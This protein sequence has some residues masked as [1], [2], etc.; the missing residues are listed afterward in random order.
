MSSPEG[1]KADLSLVTGVHIR[2][3]GHASH[4]RVRINKTAGLEKHTSSG[5]VS[6]YPLSSLL[7]Y[8]NNWCFCEFQYKIIHQFT[9]NSD[10]DR[11][12]S[13]TQASALITGSSY[14]LLLCSE[15]QHIQHLISCSERHHP[16]GILNSQDIPL[17]IL[18][19][20]SHAKD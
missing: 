12:F 5:K 10:C 7:V 17:S 11:N 9:L 3:T 8:E 1:K 4:S 13:S 2:E 20:I 19:P 16:C 6:L 15:Q 18:F 14:K